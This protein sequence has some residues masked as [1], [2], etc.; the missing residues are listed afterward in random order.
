MNQILPGDPYP[1]GAT[2]DGEGVNFA[3]F[4]EHA[5]KVE[6]C[7]FDTPTAGKESACIALPEQRDF[8]W[9]GYVPGLAVGQLYGYRI[10]GPY[11]PQKGYRFNSFKVLL[12]PC[13]KA[14]GRRLQWGDEAF[15]YRIG[16]PAEDLALDERDNAGSAPLGVVIDPAFDWGNDRP[17]RRLWRDTVIYEA[18]VKGFYR[19]VAND[20]RHYMD[21]TGCGNTLNMT[22]PRVLQIIMDSLRYWVTEMHVD[23]F[24]FDLAA[25]LAR[26]FHEV[27]RLG[28]FFDIIHQAVM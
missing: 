6:L 2:W 19:L 21:Y 12:D 4:T 22:H 27:D 9:H 20:R 26:E 8:V 24:R 23:G 5:E 3:I 1:L 14:I 7:L 25:A 15:G 16:D 10:H 17:P 18:H 13:A 11:E 28:A